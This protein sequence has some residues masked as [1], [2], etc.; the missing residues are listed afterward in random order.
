[1]SDTRDEGAH[2]PTNREL[3]AEAK[4]LGE[5]LGLEV[6][7]VGLNK[8]GLLELLEEL[9][10]RRAAGS[11]SRSAP[12]SEPPAGQASS[13]SSERP[14]PA[15]M[16]LADAAPPSRELGP[17]GDDPPRERLVVAK[18]RSLMSRSRGVLGPGVEVEPEDLGEESGRRAQELLD[19]GVLELERIR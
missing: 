1:M 6:S 2:A 8:A 12:D 14:E 10:A 4:T 16:A 13:G 19:I 15:S 7:T 17:F 3:A 11:A 9:R 18:R 5:E